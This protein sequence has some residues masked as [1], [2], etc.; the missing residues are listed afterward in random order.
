MVSVLLCLAPG[1]KGLVLEPQ[2]ENGGLEE[3][4]STVAGLKLV[5]T[6]THMD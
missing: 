4:T 6:G 2:S 5:S 1:Q 3:P